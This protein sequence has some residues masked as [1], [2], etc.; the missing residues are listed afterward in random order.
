MI[1]YSENLFKMAVCMLLVDKDKKVL[2]TRR[3]MEMKLFPHAWVLPGGHV[4]N[5][6][7]LEV[8]VIREL[9]EETGIIIET[10][11][12]KDGREIYFY[13]GKQVKLRPFY[14]F[15]SVSMLVYDGSEPPSS[16]HLILF[17]TIELS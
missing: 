2:I 16:C 4:D 1:K 10:E 9:A 7:T 17:F 8:A 3:T 14:A 15:E 5:G 13:H 6:E 11:V 12:T